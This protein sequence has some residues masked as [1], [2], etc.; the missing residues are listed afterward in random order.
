MILDFSIFK[1]LHYV[2][3]LTKFF[4]KNISL[5]LKEIKTLRWIKVK[6]IVEM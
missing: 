2:Q 3:C 6:T 1:I 4:F 5:K